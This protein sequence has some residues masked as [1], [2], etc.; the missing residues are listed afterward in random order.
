MMDR[1]GDDADI[2]DGDDIVV[3]DDDDIVVNDDGNDDSVK[4]YTCIYAYIHTFLR[5]TYT[6]LHAFDYLL[7]GMMRH[8]L[9][10]LGALKVY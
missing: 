6:Y 10:S 4:Y 7:I 2:D 9:D 8:I 1:D 5:S 3:V